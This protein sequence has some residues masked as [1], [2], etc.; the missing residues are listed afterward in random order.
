MLECHI[1]HFMVALTSEKTMGPRG[2]DVKLQ[3]VWP[4]VKE[5]VD[6]MEGLVRFEWKTL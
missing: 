5:E 3:K 4:S 1:H 2:L 6:K